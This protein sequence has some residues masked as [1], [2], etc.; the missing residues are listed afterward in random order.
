MRKYAIT[1]GFTGKLF[2]GLIKAGNIL[3][4]EMNVNYIFSAHAKLN[5]PIVAGETNKLELITKMI[6]RIKYKKFKL[7]MLGFGVFA[8]KK[9]LLYL[10][11]EQNS[12]LLKLVQLIN[13]RT[14]NLFNKKIDYYGGIPSFWVPKTSIAYKDFKYS[15]LELILKKI[16]FLHNSKYAMINS[17]DLIDFTEEK[18]DILLK[19]NYLS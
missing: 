4:K 18:R 12:D 15:Q 13:K 11:W 17:I 5:I 2:E 10:R 3:S 14:S 6:K 19:E 8:N 16:N 7:K 1:L 9:P